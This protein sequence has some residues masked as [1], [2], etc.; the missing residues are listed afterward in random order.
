[1]TDNESPTYEPNFELPHHGVIREDN[2]PEYEAKGFNIIENSLGS[3]SEL[4]AAQAVFGVEHVYTGDA[5]DEGEGRPLHHK[6]GTGIYTNAE[7]RAVGAETVRKW[8]NWYREQ[9]YDFVDDPDR[10]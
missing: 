1:M 2:W 7:G 3:T 6:P 8:Q 10:S 5:W 4:N 9:G